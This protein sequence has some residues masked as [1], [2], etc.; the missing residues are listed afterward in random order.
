MSGLKSK[1]KESQCVIDF[2]NFLGAPMVPTPLI[3]CNLCF[4]SLPCTM[5]CR[6]KEEL[7]AALDQRERKVT[8]VHLEI[9]GPLVVTEYLDY[10]YVMLPHKNYYSI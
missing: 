5:C 8:R 7:K 6:V 2:S 10:P 4:L 1:L 9:E 3:L